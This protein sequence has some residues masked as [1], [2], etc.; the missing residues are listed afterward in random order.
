ML[1]LTRPLAVFDLETTGV[2]VGVDRVVSIGIIRLGGASTEEDELARLAYLLN[3]GRPIPPEATAVHGIRD[4]DVA[5][6]PVFADVAR[7]I[8]REL[9]GCD[10]AG[11]NVKSFDVPMLAA[12]FR[13]VGIT[14]PA[15]GQRIVD[16]FRVY[17][18]MEPRT[19]QAA[20]R[21]YAKTEHTEAHSAM[22]DAEMTAQILLE[23]AKLYGVSDIEALRQLERDP[24][25]LDEEGKVKWQGDVAVLNFGKWS[26]TPLAKVERGY[27]DW[28][29]RQDFPSD[30]LAIIKAAWNRDYP[31]RA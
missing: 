5:A 11:F 4:K 19:L 29:L 3:P 18:R 13:R 21:Y 1:D 27:L 22:A 24:E 14:W 8:H 28:M 31:K 6:C 25:W 7:G 20:A 16:A 10:L 30:T 12:E 23:Q 17:N 26:G 15:E 9:L 2:D